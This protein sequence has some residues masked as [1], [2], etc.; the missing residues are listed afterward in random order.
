MKKIIRLSFIAIAIIVAS[1]LGGCVTETVTINFETNGGNV[2]EAVTVNINTTDITV[3]DPVKAGHTFVEWYTDADLTTIFDNTAAVTTSITLYA[4]WTKLTYN[5][6]I[7]VD[8]VDSEPQ[9]IEYGGNA[10]LPADPVKT[11]YTFTGWFVG[12]TV[13][14]GTNI[15]AN[16]TIT[17]RFV[18]IDFTITFKDANNDTLYTYP[19]SY[20]HDLTTIPTVPAI[21]GKTAAWSITNFTN[22]TSNL[23]VTP[24]YEDIYYTVTYMN[25]L[26]KDEFNEDILVAS[27]LG[28]VDVIYGGN[29]PTV[30]TADIIDGYTYSGNH[31]GYTFGEAITESDITII[32]YYDINVYTVSFWVLGNM[33]DTQEVEWHTSAEVPEYVVPEG[34][35]TDDNWSADFSSVEQNLVIYLNLTPNTYTITFVLGGEATNVLVNAAYKSIIAEPT[36]PTRDGFAFA[37]WFTDED[38]TIPYI[39]T[40]NS[41]MPLNGM[42]L[43]AGWDLTSGV[44]VYPITFNITFV[45]GDT[46]DYSITRQMV[47]GMIYT[48]S[49]SVTGYDFVS[50]E[51]NGVAYVGSSY[52]ITAAATTIDLTY[53]L[54][55]LNVSFTPIVWD[56]DH[57]EPGVPIIVNVTYGGAL[58]PDQIPSLPD[59]VGYYFAWDHSDFSNITD[60]ISVHIIYYET[61][62]KTLILMNQSTVI[63]YITEDN[64][65]EEEIDLPMFSASS[66]LNS[67]QR[68]GYVF[69]GWFNQT[70]GGTQYDLSTTS[71]ATLT[72]SGS[73][74]LYAQ[75]L[76]LEEFEAPTGIT[77]TGQEIAWDQ[78]PIDLTFYPVSY[79]IIIDGVETIVTVTDPANP[80]YTFSNGRLILP[81]THSVI[82]I[83]NGNETT[84]TSSLNSE[85]FTFTIAVQAQTDDLGEVLETE[86]RDYYIVEYAE[87]GTTYVFYTDMDYTFNSSYIFSILSGGEYASVPQ[88]NILSIGNTPG[89]FRFRVQTPSGLK[90]YY[91][92]IVQFVG[93][94]ALGDSLADYTADVAFLEDENDSNDPYVNNT[95][96][97]YLV[98]SMNDFHFELTILDRMGS[99]VN[100]AMCELV[101][102]FY[103][104]ETDPEAEVE[105][106]LLEGAELSNYVSESASGV[107][108]F[109]FKSLANGQEFRVEIAPK[110]QATMVTV[111]L[112][113]FVFTVNNGYNVF[114]N[115]QMKLYFSDLNVDII[116]VHSD[117]IAVLNANQ[118]NADG[119][120][121][122][123]IATPEDNGVSFT[124]ED[125]AHYRGNV[126]MR[127]GTGINDDNF[128][129]NGNY[130]TIDGS[131]LPFCNVNSDPNGGFTT[132]GFEGAFDVVSVQISIIYYFVQDVKDAIT[133]DNRFTINNLTVIGNT[134]TPSVNYADTETIESQEALMSRNSGGL[135]GVMPRAGEA[136]FNNLNVSNTTI[137]FFS[138]IYGQNSAEEPLYMNLDYVHAEDS[139][140][141]SVY[142]WAITGVTVTNSIIDKSGGAAIHVEDTRHGTEGIEDPY[143]YLDNATQVNNWVSGEE[144]WFKA[145]GKT[146]L[147]LSIKSMVETGISPLGKTIIKTVI[148]DVTG[149]ETEKMNLVILC[150]A[151]IDVSKYGVGSEVAMDFEDTNNSITS[152]E[153]A[154]DFI[155]TDPRSSGGAFAFIVGDYSD[156]L[157]FIDAI[158]YLMT[159]Y[160]AYG[161]TQSQA[162]QM[163]YIA[164]FYNLPSLDLAAQAAMA[165]ATDPEQDLTVAE[166]V[167]GV[168]YA[169]GPIPMPDQPRYLEIANEVEA[170]TGASIIVIEMNNNDAQ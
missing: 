96:T 103:L 129:V 165:V 39:F 66:G 34:Y 76:D 1:V 10:I 92:K 106:V 82:I 26:G 168:L 120:P 73:I 29:I 100:A 12:N 49:Q 38:C 118:I 79:T 42:S 127:L 94:F 91:G 32:F 72:A 90:T 35:F 85:T 109:D 125:G 22:I 160:A 156:P 133:N 4:K 122:N 5:V 170:G 87:E 78:Q 56:T 40:D 134:V 148:S 151:Q 124:D 59:T 70:A 13:T 158:T 17:A 144:A 105:W 147:A 139:W 89:T 146:S 58:T 95:V 45:G 121:M 27:S 117:I 132:T 107:G 130:F 163:V 20:G 15:A 41:E 44:D 19:V 68:P 98:G 52:T 131:D 143:I 112:V 51:I 157:A 80:S 141:N 8:G 97:P 24:V 25:S 86:I 33:I 21:T 88:D 154:F 48:P 101:Y 111:P 153:R 23:T 108:Y 115:E 6:V 77:V 69:L 37:G 30:P 63:Y 50:M 53:Q 9:V 126:Y 145:Y 140:A 164:A 104:H 167:A 149:L 14:D 16:Q 28:S 135:C 137:A 84:N 47:P 102:N 71:F 61:T 31:G 46:S 155:S 162:A 159:T 136:F 99:R 11:G 75:W 123:G 43:Y 138:C 152:I 18:I 114:T 81:G 2:M 110:Y 55:T 64:F 83:A 3:A 150:M 60:N 7:S 142:G 36:A 74:V 62:V 161:V 57:F 54:K 116:N 67:L 166:A 65:S 93:T 169:N 119:S 113:T 128:V